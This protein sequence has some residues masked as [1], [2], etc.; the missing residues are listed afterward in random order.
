MN[1]FEDSINLLK[2][3]AFTNIV[4]KES[5][6]FLE[7]PAIFNE[8]IV[9]LTFLDKFETQEAHDLFLT[10]G[11]S[12]NLSYYIRNTLLDD[13]TDYLN[14]LDL[15][16]DYVDVYLTYTS[17]EIL[18]PELNDCELRKVDEEFFD[19]YKQVALE[20]FPNWSNEEE[21]VEYFNNLSKEKNT[22]K[23]YTDYALI[24]DGQIISIASTIYDV[25]ANL[26]YIH[27]AGTVL[28]YRRKG[29]FTLINKLL[30]NKAFDLGINRSYVI[31]EKDSESFN[32]YKK[33]GFNEEDEYYSFS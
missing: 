16:L 3:T 31:V 15:S 5:Y 17:N 1:I 33:I 27:N 8:Y 18:N 32:A 9:P 7:A 12:T 11:D 24:K 13:Y 19:E 14:S 6:I 22:D 10:K 2:G 20:I 25:K 29:Y 23:I 26:A 4:V 21:Y 28:E 30:I